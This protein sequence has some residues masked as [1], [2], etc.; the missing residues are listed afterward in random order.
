M[1]RNLDSFIK[2]KTVPFQLLAQAVMIWLIRS[3]ATMNHELTLQ[4][5]AVEA[6]GTPVPNYFLSK[7]MWL[8]QFLDVF[9]A[10]YAFRIAAQL[11]FVAVILPSLEDV[12]SSFSKTPSIFLL[13]YL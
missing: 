3:L 2:F 1:Q 13:S 5:R 12:G 7:L 11:A 10:S 8:S 6:V 4:V 9:V